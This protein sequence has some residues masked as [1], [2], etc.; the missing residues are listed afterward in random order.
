MVY[1]MSGCVLGQG[2]RETYCGEILPTGGVM[3]AALGNNIYQ[4]V[5]KQDGA[6]GEV[7]L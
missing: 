4:G 7:G 3:G 5:R 1:L 6:E 2:L